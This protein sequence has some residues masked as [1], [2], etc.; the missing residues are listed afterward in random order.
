MKSYIIDL[1]LLSDGN[2]IQEVVVSG[3]TFK[4]R[5]IISVENSLVFVENIQNGM[6]SRDAFCTFAL[7]MHCES[8]KNKPR[9]STRRAF[10]SMSDDEALQIMQYVVSG[11]D[12]V[13]SELW[14]GDIG[15]IYERFKEFIYGYL[16]FETRNM[17][18]S[19]NLVIEN[20]S[21]QMAES[22]ASSLENLHG[23][24]ADISANIVPTIQSAF[25]QL[26]GVAKKYFATR[27]TLDPVMNE[28]GWGGLSAIPRN[29]VQYVSTN[30]LEL[31]ASD[32]DGLIQRYFNS[33][34]YREL[35]Y[36]LDSWYEN[37]YYLKRKSVLIE[38][39]E[40]YKHNFNIACVTLL[41]IHME[42]IIKSFLYEHLKME[43]NNK[44]SIQK[45]FDLLDSNADKNIAYL[46]E[47]SKATLDEVYTR[48]TKHFPLSK[49]EDTSNF[50]R[51]KIAHG[52]MYEEIKNTDALKTWLYMDEL[53]RLLNFLLKDLSN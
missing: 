26:G 30:K 48:L 8:Q 22:W 41:T 7:T 38:A 52:Q 47:C 16:T 3:K 13:P 23:M 46:H 11:C 53:N 51:H 28:F 32:V 39:V 45:L 50:S 44:K 6:S 35:N 5:I 17:I 15:D 18:G 20:I 10:N 27:K 49:P 40:C 21:N 12:N 37:P 29:I 25:E 14:N 2:V 9:N 36:L 42:G 43:A 19:L 33:N 31:S 1:G 4:L 34:N 24:I